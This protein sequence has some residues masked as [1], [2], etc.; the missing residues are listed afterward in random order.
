M[1]EKNKR[2]VSFSLFEFQDSKICFVLQ[3]EFKLTLVF[4][5]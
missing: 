4:S 3:V 2:I 1:L 5:P